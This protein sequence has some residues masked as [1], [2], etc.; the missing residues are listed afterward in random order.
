MK[1]AELAPAAG[2]EQRG[3]P[4]SGREAGAQLSEQPPR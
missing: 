1:L 4:A 3:D 2:A